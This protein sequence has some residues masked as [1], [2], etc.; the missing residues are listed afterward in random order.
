MPD[1]RAM[2]E[3]KQPPIRTAPGRVYR[4]TRLT[5]HTPPCSHRI[6][7]LVVVGVLADLKGTLETL[8]EAI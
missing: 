8:I 6:E 7:G 5:Q 3:I 1:I 2:D 4:R